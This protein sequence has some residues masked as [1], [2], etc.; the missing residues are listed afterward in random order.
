MT[1][2]PRSSNTTSTRVRRA[3]GGGRKGERRRSGSTPRVRSRWSAYQDDLASRGVN[4]ACAERTACSRNGYRFEGEHLRV[5]GADPLM[6]R[7]MVPMSRSSP[8]VR[9][10]P[11]P[12]D[13]TQHQHR[14]N[15]ARAEQVPVFVSGVSTDGDQPRACGAG[16]CIVLRSCPGQRHAI[17]DSFIAESVA[18]AHRYQC[19]QGRPA[20]AAILQPT[21]I[22]AGV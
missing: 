6:A 4:P 8:R 19:G 16:S 17:F 14:I 11:R 1:L 20:N 13:P 9:S 10:G 2:R 15:P 18:S 3:G 5:C 21:R 7:L 12:A 22:L